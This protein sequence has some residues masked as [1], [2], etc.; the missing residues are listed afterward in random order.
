MLYHAYFRTRRG[1]AGLLYET[2]RYELLAAL[3]PRCL[4][5]R[6]WPGRHRC[7]FTWLGAEEDLLRLCPRLGYTRAVLRETVTPHVAE[8]DF[9]MAERW[10]VG[11]MRLGE[12]DRLLEEL[13][14]ADEEERLA[15]SPH[16]R[17]FHF[18]GDAEAVV[19]GPRRGRRL[20]PLDARA[21]ANM[22][23][24]PD[25]AVV[26]DPFAGLGTIPLACAARGLRAVASDVEPALLPGL[27]EL[28]LPLITLADAG[29]LPF[30]DG[31]FDGVV[32]EPPYHRYDREAVLRAVPEMLRVTRRG[33]VLVLL[34]AD[35]LTEVLAIPSGCREEATL[36][37]PR[38][39]L[40]CTALVWRVVG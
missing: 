23:G 33:G 27:S 25:G 30:A 8:P 38:S 39:G 28:G 12:T 22:T 6:E 24:L 29:A 9:R 11:R 14:L 16:L 10:P 34:V 13:W 3:G 40:P 21:L 35:Y 32:T 2:C 20:S 17:A 26:L 37:V 36:P 7:T 15:L 31:S 5:E 4:L 1:G 18:E 19:G